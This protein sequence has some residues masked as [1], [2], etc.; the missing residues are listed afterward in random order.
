[1]N[2]I[3]LHPSS[4]LIETEWLAP[5]LRPFGTQVTS[6]IPDGFPAYTRML[7]PARGINDEQIPW[8]DVAVSS[9]RTMHRLVQ[10]HAI[11]RPPFRR[12]QV[13][14]TPPENGI[15][16]SGLLKNSLRRFG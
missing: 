14:V 3:G 2:Q 1:L 5:R 11:N 8:A 6:V 9:G 12:S 16:P 13:T 7:H 15:L 4:R 10:F